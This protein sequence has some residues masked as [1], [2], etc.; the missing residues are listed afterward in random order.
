MTKN[1]IEQIQLIII[2]CGMDEPVDHR[3]FF[4][5]LESNWTQPFSFFN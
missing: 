3:T 1:L 5:I 2:I 4:Q